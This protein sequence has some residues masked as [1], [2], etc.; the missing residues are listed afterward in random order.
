MNV[1]RIDKGFGDAKVLITTNV[2]SEFEIFHGDEEKAVSIVS[3]ILSQSCS[4][5]TYD[6]NYIEDW[7]KLSKR[8]G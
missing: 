3:T 7:K 5:W 6:A 4:D 2:I 1:I 8:Y